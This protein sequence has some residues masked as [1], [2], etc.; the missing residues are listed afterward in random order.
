VN[1]KLDDKVINYGSYLR[2]RQDAYH[3]STEINIQLGEF[4]LKTR[5]LEIL[6]EHI[7]ERKD[8]QSVFGKTSGAVQCAEV[9]RTEKQTWLR[10][11]GLR[12]DVRMWQPDERKPSTQ[13]YSRKYDP[14][15]GKTEMWIA[16]VLEPCR[17]GPLEGVQLYLRDSRYGSSATVARLQGYTKGFKLPEAIVSDEEEVEEDR[18]VTEGR[19]RRSSTRSRSSSMAEGKAKASE[20]ASEEPDVM[21]SDELPTLKEVIVFRQSRVVH[22]YNVVEHGRKYYRKL[23]YSSDARW[24]LHDMTPRLVLRKEWQQKEE[25]FEYVARYESGDPME[26]EVY[27]TSL[28]ITRTRPAVGL[29]TYVPSR[30]LFGLLPTAL[31]EGYMFW[32]NDTGGLTGYQHDAGA[33]GIITK[34]SVDIQ[35]AG[36]SNFIGSIQR[37]GVQT[38]ATLVDNARRSRSGVIDLGTAT[39]NST[40]LESKSV[41]DSK[42]GDRETLE[43]MNLLYAPEGTM[44]FDLAQ[45]LVRLENLSHCLVWSVRGTKEIHLIELPRL[46]L[47]FRSRLVTLA[48]GQT[49]S[50]L[51]S[52]DHDGLFISNYQSK[53]IGILMDGIPHSLVL[54]NIHQDLFLLVPGA[55]MPIRPSIKEDKFATEIVFDRSNRT[56]LDNLDVRHYLYP[57]HKSKT[58]LFTPTF[59]SALYLML[60]RFFN[61]QYAVVFRLADSCVTGTRCSVH[62]FYIFICLVCSSTSLYMLATCYLIHTLLQTRASLTRSAKSSSSLST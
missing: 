40:D 55:A 15:L 2:R 41:N 21:I 8:F 25:T 30:L 38:S 54:E 3:V 17:V 37:T 16:R 5:K 47:S 62:I 60:L 59:A 27:G 11:V 34:I 10:L 13:G 22:I 50:R 1:L 19:E 26:S 52:D 58:F 51:Y 24:C 48:D 53:L 32:Q 28:I 57:V 7:S 46:R 44:L 61:R 14:N 9:K 20:K 45:L 23:V 42:V 6:S 4:T 29:E 39:N 49:V 36:G 12:H 56:W 18:V 33:D 43:L 35:G 31:L